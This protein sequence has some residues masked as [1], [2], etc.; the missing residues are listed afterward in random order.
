MLVRPVI[1]SWEPKNIERI[2]SWE[3]RRLAVCLSR[4]FR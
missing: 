4:A 3:N 1:G 2:L